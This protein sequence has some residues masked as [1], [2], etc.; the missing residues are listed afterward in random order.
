VLNAVSADLLETGMELDAASLKA[1][2]Q[3]P[4][5]PLDED[6]AFDAVWVQTRAA[7]IATHCMKHAVFAD[8]AGFGDS[9]T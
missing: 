2:D 9:E 4:F 6:D 1:L 8:G 5:G 7:V 3:M